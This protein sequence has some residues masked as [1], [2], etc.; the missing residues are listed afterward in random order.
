M[1]PQTSRIRIVIAAVSLLVLGAVIGI[2]A[3]RLHGRAAPTVFSPPSP[4]EALDAL[5]RAA[6]LRPEQRERID[7]ILSAHQ[8]EIDAAW[9]DARTHVERTVNG[10]ITEI[11]AVLDPAQVAPF[12]ALVERIHGQALPI[13]HH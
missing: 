8:L 7:S 4:R 6:N 12:R 5:D 9:R 13:L 10:V 11:E 2:S 3:E 1:K